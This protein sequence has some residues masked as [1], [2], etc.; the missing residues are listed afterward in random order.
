MTPD[1]RASLEAMFEAFAPAH[2]ER[3]SYLL[4]K[5]PERWGKISP[6]LAWPV[7]NPYKSHP[8]KPLADILRSEPVVR[9]LATPSVIL[10]CGHSSAP[11]VKTQALQE[12]FPDG[13][14]NYDVVFEGFIS[15]VPG[16]LALGFN[17]E[18]GLCVYGA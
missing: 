14:W 17:H 2:Q 4:A 15:V 16:K 7:A 10:R 9:F 1:E 5:R 13:K 8:D 3:W 12:A 11:S 6:L 18:G